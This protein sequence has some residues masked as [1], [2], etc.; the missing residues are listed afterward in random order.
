MSADPFSPDPLSRA[1]AKMIADLDRG[2]ARREHGLFRIEGW[3][4]LASAVQAGVTL[5]DIVVRMDALNDGRLELLRSARANLI[6][7]VRS[8]G[9]ARL[10]SVLQD[11]GVV[12]TARIQLAP[13][14]AIAGVHRILAM[15]GV[16]DPGN[17]GTLIR[18]AAWFGVEAVMAGGD[19]ADFFNPKAVRASAGAIWDLALVRMD[20]LPAGLAYMK[21]LGFSCFGA[22]LSRADDPNWRNAE[23]SILVLGSEGHGLSEAVKSQLDGVVHVSGRRRATSGVESLNVATA[24]SILISRWAD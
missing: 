24:G 6:A 23:K 21:G 7:S 5:E 18:S 1:R 19:T 13:V 11:Q 20:D 3:R 4:A 15:D 17:V 8:K 22:D 14:A 16:Q 9:M 12:A 10:T 2:S